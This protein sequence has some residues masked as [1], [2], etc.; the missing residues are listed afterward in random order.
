REILKSKTSVSAVSDVNVLIYVGSTMQLYE[1][2]VFLSRLSNLYSSIRRNASLQIGLVLFAGPYTRLR[3]DDDRIDISIQKTFKRHIQWRLI[4]RI[5]R[6]AFNQLQAI[7]V[8]FR[9]ET[10]KQANSYICAL[11]RPDQ[12]S[13]THGIESCTGKKEEDFLR[14]SMEGNRIGL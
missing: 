7:Y 14:A 4:L 11:C 10:V 13:L 1:K 5:S 8:N 3:V 6:P 12:H 2:Q 9:V